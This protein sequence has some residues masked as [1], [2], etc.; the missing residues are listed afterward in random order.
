MDS[1]IQHD[2]DRYHDLDRHHDRPAPLQPQDLPGR[3]GGI[4]TSHDLHVLRPDTAPLTPPPDRGPLLTPQQVAAL[5]GGV[6]AAWVRRRVPGK[7]VL[8]QR[9]VRWY[10]ADVLA[11]VDSQQCNT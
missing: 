5:I 7:I 4:V 1:E 9:T 8:G 3:R 2:V 11:W 6:S 10:R